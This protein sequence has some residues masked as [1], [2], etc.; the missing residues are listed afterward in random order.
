MSTS[1]PISSQQTLLLH[2]YPLASDMWAAQRRALEQAGHTVIAPDLPG[3]GG[4]PGNMARLH[5]TASEL[6]TTLPAGPLNIVGLSMGGYLAFE[7]LRQEPER[8]VRAVLADT[9][10]RADTPEKKADREA[11]AV[12]V[13]HEGTDFLLESAEQEHPAHTF[14]VI[15]P[16]IQQAT[17][18]GVAGALRAMAARPD[19]RDLLPSL[20]D[21]VAVLG[22][23]GRKDSLTPPEIVSEIVG[24]SGGQLAIIEGAGH[25]SNLD[26]EQDFT[27]V[28]LEFLD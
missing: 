21:K 23:V 15:K 25:L 2:A 11:Q 19:S 16:L 6:L 4:M 3:F 12:R 17:P 5:D 14:A 7:L 27:R 13:L 22:I 24:L 8:F 1:S 10:A 28:M 9:S 26:K 18:Q 20:V